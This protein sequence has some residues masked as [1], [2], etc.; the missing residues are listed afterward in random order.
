MTPAT[1]Y[2]PALRREIRRA[3]RLS[4]V[5][6]VRAINAQV[7]DWCCGRADEVRAVVG[8][9]TR[10]WSEGR[11]DEA[12]AAD[13]IGSYVRGVEEALQAWVR[14]ARGGSASRTRPPNDTIV[15]G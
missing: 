2:P 5:L 3:A 9:A 7:S 13:R 12:R 10:E 8:D 15:D 6:T 11:L 4:S 1:V 14:A